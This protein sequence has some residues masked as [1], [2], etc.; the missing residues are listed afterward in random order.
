[1]KKD[2]ITMDIETTGLAPEY[3]RV[4]CICC[5][6]SEGERELYQRKSKRNIWKKV[7]RR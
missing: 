4:T 5:K 2:I 3:N 6:T 1:M 7:A